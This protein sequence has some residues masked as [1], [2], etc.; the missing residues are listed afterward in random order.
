M[1]P[2]ELYP[3]ALLSSHGYWH[4]WCTGWHWHA[5]S[6]ALLAPVSCCELPVPAAGAA[7][8]PAHEPATARAL[9]LSAGTTTQCRRTV[10]YPG[11]ADSDSDSGLAS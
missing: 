3:Q 7:R 2:Q 10:Q 6:R 11:I 9:Q 4:H 5:H 1:Y 8:V